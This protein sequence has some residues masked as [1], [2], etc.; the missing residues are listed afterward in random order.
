M[1]LKGTVENIIFRN[2]DN[3]YTVLEMECNGLV[4]LTGTFPV[5]NQGDSIEV[6]GEFKMG[7]YGEQF[8]VSSVR[9]L[10]P[11]TP[12]SIEKFLAS[13]LFKGIGE[14]TA[15]MLVKQFGKDT[16][17]VIENHPDRLTLVRGIGARKAAEIAE[18]YRE[19]RELQ[20]TVMFLQERGVTVGLAL[21]IYKT[22]REKTVDVLKKNPYRLVDDV[23]GVGFRT[24][25]VLAEKLGFDTKSDFRLRAGI[26]YVLQSVASQ[27]GSTCMPFAEL[28]TRSANVLRTPVEEFESNAERILSDLKLEGHVREIEKNGVRIFAQS[29]VWHTE[30]SLAQRLSAL[31]ENTTELF[32]DI[33]WH[34][35][36]YERVN[37]IELHEKQKEAISSCCKA[38]VSV[39][40]GGPGTGKTTIIRCILS[41]FRAM[42]L[43]TALLAPTGRAAKRLAETTGEE[44]STIHRMLDL[45]F[46]NGKGN[47]TYNE[48]NKLPHSAIIV[49]EVSMTDIYVM[50]ALLRAVKDGAR[51]ILVGDR[52]QLPSVGAGNVLSDTI[53]SGM[54]NTVCLT[55]VYR[56]G[57][58]SLIITNAHRINSGEMPLLTNRDTDFFFDSQSDQK[59]M[60]KRVLEMV[61]ITVPRYASVSSSDIQVLAP[62]KK[63]LCGVENLN[64]CLQEVLNGREPGKGEFLYEGMIFREGDR[65]MHTTNDYQLEWT[66]VRGARQE[67]GQGVFNGDIGR[68]ELINRAE[69]E[70]VVE[71]E[72]GRIV[73]YTEA[74]LSELTLSYAISVHKSQGCEFDVVIIPVTG[75]HPGLFTRNLL[76]TAVTRAKKM[77]VLVGEKYNVKRMVDNNYVEKRY[78]L[79]R[80][81]LTGEIL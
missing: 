65:V 79:L 2:E 43:K 22:Y 57:K 19:V 34:V 39:I 64:R 9:I 35:T 76:Y 29:S 81:F 13:G 26:V 53:A 16:L 50:N 46:K 27:E 6:E 40:T 12:E 42:G 67:F 74:E 78:T 73:R 11:D 56:Q 52:D 14:V 1:L 66:R 10:T 77:V 36:E 61:T 24:A 80:E 5:I 3:C 44:A 71:F 62:M 18:T 30:R 48:N 20:E 63:G 47:F 23:D 72:D 17:D 28:V 54:V 8:V 59:E 21:R 31:S 33:D 70:L 51:L 4:T 37:G 15:Y 55:E 45:D 32:A 41:V 7:K 75:G 38:G 58:E 69:G 25:D 49:D 68:I 60:L